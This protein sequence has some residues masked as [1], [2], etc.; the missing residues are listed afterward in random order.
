MLVGSRKEQ[1]KDSFLEVAQN[2]A[3]KKIYLEKRED[4]G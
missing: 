2:L 4:V 3:K 1:A